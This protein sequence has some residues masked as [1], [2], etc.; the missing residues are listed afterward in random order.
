MAN[1]T[2]SGYLASATAVVFS[3]TQQ[4]T[5][6]A[7]NEWTDLSDEIDNSTNKYRLAD[8]DLILGSA[9]FIATDPG[10][11]VYVVPTVDGTTYPT[12]TGN[13]TSDAPE[14]QRYFACWL[15][16]K[17]QNAAQ[18]VVSPTDIPI[19]LPQGKFKFGVRSRANVSLAAS[20]NTL[21]YRPHTVAI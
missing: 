20:G 8:L 16:L 21:Y 17:V 15:P 9:N 14:N 4:L 11:E 18:R 3:G 6:L 10:I 19:A 12:W 5:S 13:T 2:L 7:D 1:L